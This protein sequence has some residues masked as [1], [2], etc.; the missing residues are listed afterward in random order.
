[1]GRPYLARFSFVSGTGPFETTPTSPA[2]S[3]DVS[4]KV[5]DEA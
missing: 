5:S 3:F 1:M 2:F 4:P